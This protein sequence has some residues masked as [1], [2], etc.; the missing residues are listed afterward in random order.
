M[1]DESERMDSS[2]KQP[3]VAD[4][5]EGGEEKEVPGTGEEEIVEEIISQ[6]DMRARRLAKFSSTPSS[7]SKSSASTDVQFPMDLGTEP[8]PDPTP[9]RTV[10]PRSEKPR[11]HTLLSSSPSGSSSLTKYKSPSVEKPTPVELTPEEVSYT[12]N[13]RYIEVKVYLLF[14]RYNRISFYKLL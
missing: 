11:Q 10:P 13:S 2:D 4:S 12:I 6:E 3:E 7:Q 1:S 8:P 14:V 9:V 5:S